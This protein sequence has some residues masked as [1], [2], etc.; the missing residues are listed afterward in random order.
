MTIGPLSVLS[1]SVVSNSL[2]TIQTAAHQASLSMG[3]SQ[4]R[5]L[6]WVVISSPRGSSQPKDWTYISC[7]GRWLLYHWAIWESQGHEEK[8]AKPRTHLN[9]WVGHVVSTFFC[10]S[11]AQLCLTLCNPMDCSTPGFPVPHHL[12]E[13]AQTHVHWV[14]DAIQ[15]SLPLSSPSPPAFDLFQHQG[16]F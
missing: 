4:A 8:C 14:S 9:G 10:C 13:F 3:L 2:V 7:T 5:I 15:A 16:I 11:V 12:L 6:A 1:H